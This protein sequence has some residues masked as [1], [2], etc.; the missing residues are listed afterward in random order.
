M[1]E[2]PERDSALLLDMLLAAQDAQAFV[3]GLDE[4]AFLASRLH[5]NACIRSLEVIGEAAGKV[6]ARPHTLNSVARNHGNAPSSHPRLWRRASRPCLDRASRSL[7]SFARN[8]G[9]TCP[10]RRVS[11]HRDRERSF[12]NKRA[13]G[14]TRSRRHTLLVRLPARLDVVAQH[15]IDLPFPALAVEDAV[16]ADTGLEMVGLHIGP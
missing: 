10:A 9:A 4:A 12:R 16:M 13:G 11:G 6:S 8:I 5:Q 1:A 7:A 15:R 2:L 14:E 3:K